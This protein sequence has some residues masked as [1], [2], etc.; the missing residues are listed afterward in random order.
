MKYYAYTG[1]I[2]ELKKLGYEFQ[3]LY[4]RNYKTYSKD[5]ITMYVTS[6]MILEI[7][8][9][10]AKLRTKYI[11]F[12]LANKDKPKEFWVRDE[13][14]TMNPAKPVFFKDAPIWFITNHGSVMRSDDFYDKQVPI[15]QQKHQL[16]SNVRSGVISK[17]QYDIK[18]DKLK[19]DEF[20]WD[21]VTF[22][23]KNVNQII[24][25]DSLHPLELKVY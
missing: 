10:E 13:D 16:I 9:V 11:D 5:N 1:D 12:I 15:T 23:L 19:E 3:K 8:Y 2:K 7:S 22:S 24:E 4:A 21:P 25:L 17:E 18:N 14:L 6:K 20:Y